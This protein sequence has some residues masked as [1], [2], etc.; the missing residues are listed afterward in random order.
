MK[1]IA[2]HKSSKGMGR[3]EDESLTTH[4]QDKKTMFNVEL[5]TSIW[6]SRIIIFK[7]L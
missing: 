6:H 1:S 7:N 2:H 3:F 4:C 5:Q